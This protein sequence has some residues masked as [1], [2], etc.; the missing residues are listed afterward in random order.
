MGELAK[1][2]RNSMFNVAKDVES[3]RKANLDWSNWNKHSKEWMH[4]TTILA[5]LLHETID[6][7]D[8]R[9]FQVELVPPHVVC[10]WPS[11]FKEPGET[12]YGYRAPTM[13]ETADNPCC[14]CVPVWKR[15]FR[16]TGVMEYLHGLAAAKVNDLLPMSLPHMSVCYVVNVHKRLETIG[17]DCL[18][19]DCARLSMKPSDK[20]TE[21]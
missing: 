21:G 19:N 9:N 18:V 17:N 6:R 1:R 13:Q 8:G 2:L 16:V 20:P 10:P 14:L 7:S 4:N 3:G 5:D 11:R 12:K 15:Q